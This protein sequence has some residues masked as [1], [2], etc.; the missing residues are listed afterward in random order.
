MA[1]S[2]WE[3]KYLRLVYHAQMYT[4]YLFRRQELQCL[5]VHTGIVTK[6]VPAS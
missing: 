1:L 4:R 5:L 6:R 2:V 3:F